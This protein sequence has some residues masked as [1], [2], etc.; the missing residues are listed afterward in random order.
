MTFLPVPAG[1][2]AV[3]SN[4][5]RPQSGLESRGNCW[6]RLHADRVTVKLDIANSLNAAFCEKRVARR[7]PLKM[8]ASVRSFV[9][10]FVRDA[11]ENMFK[12]VFMSQENAPIGYRPR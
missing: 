11:Q 1:A 3:H 12:H 2:G 6:K 10:L 9:R 5:D 4:S 8:I 7:P